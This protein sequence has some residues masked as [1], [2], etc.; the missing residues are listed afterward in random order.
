MKLTAFFV[1]ILISILG[2][3]PLYLPIFVIIVLGILA[4]V[5]AI[6]VIIILLSFSISLIC[7][8]FY[9]DPKIEKN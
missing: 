4:A 5:V 3:L 9:F 7:D 1:I 8:Y 2:T 6:S